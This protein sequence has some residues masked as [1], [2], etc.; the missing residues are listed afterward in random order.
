MAGNRATPKARALGAALRELREEAGFGLREFARRLGKDPG[1]VSRIE[2]GK[3]GA[4]V[5]EIARMLTTLGVGGARYDELVEMARGGTAG[6][7]WLAVTLPEQ[8]QHLAAVL[9]FERSA[10][11][12]T[13]MAPLLIPGLLQTG[14][15]ARA[16]MSAGG[17]PVSEIETRVAIRIGRR[18]VILRRHPVHF[19]AL[20]GE[21]ALRQMIGGRNVILDQCRYLVEL[22]E[23]SNVDIRVIPFD[24]G[25]HPGL[26]TPFVLIDS[27]EAQPVVQVETRI[28]GLFLSDDDYV[29]RYRQAADKVFQVALSPSDSV[30]LIAAE[31]DRMEREGDCYRS[32]EEVQ[33]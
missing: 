30:S 10:T 13:D 8:R 29:S 16:I 24:A 7:L 28:S 23:M 9:E 31:V 20:I 1:T 2:N 25:W 4:D 19:V 17:V 22:A 27:D 12:I 18:D 3:R 6:P 15:Y 5:A 14:D 21:A 26:E 32:V 11:V 33:S